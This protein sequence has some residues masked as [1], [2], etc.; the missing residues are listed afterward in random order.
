MRQ[1]SKLPQISLQ[2]PL[3]NK[4]NKKLKKSAKTVRSMFRLY[5]GMIQTISVPFSVQK[6]GNKVKTG[7]NQKDHRSYYVTIAWV[8]FLRLLMI[9][10]TKSTSIKVAVRVL[11]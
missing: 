4:P 10:L 11:L 1:K 9:R 5:M 6:V 7:K 3:S 8:G 2:V